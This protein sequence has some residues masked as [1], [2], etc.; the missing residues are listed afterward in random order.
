[1]SEQVT[2]VPGTA[3]QSVSAKSGWTEELRATFAL[4]WPLVIAQ[5]AQNALHTTD[6]IMLGWLGPAYLAAGTLATTFL[7]PFLVGG[8]GIVGAVAPLVAQARGA[9]DIKAVRRVVRQGLWAAILLAALIIPILLQIRPIFA[10]LGQDP[11]ATVRAEQFIQ[12]A[13]W[14][15]FPALAIIALRSLLSAFDGTRMILII[16][17]SGV[18]FN[19][20]VNYLLIFGHFGFPRLELRGSAIATVLTNILM[21]GL[22]LTY[23]LRQRRF[24][25]FHV[26]LRFWKPDWQRFREIF[27][28]GTPI[29][30]TVLAEVGLF[31]AAAFLMG[32]LGT[33]EV[34]AHAIALQ[35]ASMAFMV[36]LG[37]GIAATVRVG[38]AYG[39]SDPEGIRKSGWTAFALGTGF[40]AITCI[41][42]LTVGPTIVSWFLDPRVEANANALALAATFLVVAGVFQLVDGAQVVAAHALRGLS[43]TKVPMLLAILGYWA[44]GLPIAYILGFVVGWRGVG[45]WMGLAA[46]LAFVAV[47][48]VTRFALRERLG[49]LRPR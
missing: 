40:M 37:L 31:T 28:I 8:I 34:A 13:A 10:A 19:A 20:L 25:R 6:V 18:I 27:R 45:I 1:M 43:D 5:L 21:F 36:P 9:R 49:L 44:V 47:V 42:F 15:L 39:R 48:L 4:A 23:V 33:D 29:G 16:T 46:G 26:L 24:R 41:L 22:M 30:L 38:M 17:V 35:C 2:V 11:E 7:M 14:Q 3:A 12:I 32:R